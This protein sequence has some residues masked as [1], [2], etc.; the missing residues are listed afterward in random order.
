[1]EWVHSHIARQP[2][3][4]AAEAFLFV[5]GGVGPFCAKLH[6]ANHQRCVFHHRF[7]TVLTEVYAFRVR[8][9]QVQGTVRYGRPVSEEGVITSSVVFCT[10]M[11]DPSR[12]RHP[13]RK[14]AIVGLRTPPAPPQTSRQR[15]SRPL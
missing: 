9:L 1:M 11:G 4:P 5:R 14:R 6:H 10:E 13:A 7:R 8:P 12:C 15:P 3:P 2:V